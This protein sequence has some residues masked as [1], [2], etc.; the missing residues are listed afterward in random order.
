M[1]QDFRS[2]PIIL[3]KIKYR[4]IM[5]QIK[6]YGSDGEGSKSGLVAVGG[7]ADLYGSEIVAAPTPFVIT[8]DLCKRFG[9][10]QVGNTS[11]NTDEIDLGDDIPIGTMIHLFATDVFELRTETDTVVMNNIASK[12]WTVPAADDIL[13]CFKTHATNWQITEETK[14]GLDVQVV[15]NTA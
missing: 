13:H 15:P 10:F 5:T 2:A 7:S 8:A 11:G 3:A 14:A 9:Y 4:Y 6:I 12:G 1:G